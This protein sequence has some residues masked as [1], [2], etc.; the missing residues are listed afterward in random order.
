MD[1][2]TQYT[3]PRNLPKERL[4]VDKLGSIRLERDIFH[5]F[6]RSAGQILQDVTYQN[7]PTWFASGFDGLTYKDTEITILIDLIPNSD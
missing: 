4:W 1:P 3:H 5:Q 6:S 2:Q 7:G